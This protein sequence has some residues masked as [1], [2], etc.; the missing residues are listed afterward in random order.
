MKAVLTSEQLESLRLFDTCTVANAIETFNVRL[1]NEGFAD[2]SIRCLV[3]CR[4]PMVG[5]AV[6]ATMRSSNPPPSGDHYL[7]R[8]DWWNFIVSIPPPRVVVIQDVDE[9]L[10]TGSLLGE[11][12][13]NVLMAL[14]CIGAVTNGAVRDLRAVESSGFY[15]FGGNVVVSHSYAHIVEVGGAVKVGGLRVDPGDLLH[16]DA[17][18]VLSVPHEIA[19]CIPS[20]ASKIVARERKVIELCRS[21]NFSLENLR[22][23]VKDGF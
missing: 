18:G 11:I 16:G 6:T 9:K 14:K 12:H 2:A 3:P 5:Y 21:S 4:T 23:A 10:G 22:A 19:P 15:L 17:H 20:V 13:A 7:D 1:R 8:T